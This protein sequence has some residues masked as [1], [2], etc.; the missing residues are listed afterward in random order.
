MTHDILPH[1]GEDTHKKVRFIGYMV[2][3]LLQVMLG[4]KDQDNRDG[5]MNKRIEPP[6]VL[7]G[8]ILDKTGR[9][10]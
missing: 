3:K 9:K 10:C 8:Q 1:L 7:L 5:F 4:R 2:N 6:G